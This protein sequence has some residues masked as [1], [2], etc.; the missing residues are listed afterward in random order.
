[1]AP[2]MAAGVSVSVM[3]PVVDFIVP[4]TEVVELS[5]ACSM[6]SRFSLLCAAYSMSLVPN[7][8]ELAKTGRQ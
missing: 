3:D 5:E 6:V 1:M 8:L 7:T 2:I 4:S